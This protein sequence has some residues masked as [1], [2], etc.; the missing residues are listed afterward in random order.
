MLE[1]H[2]ASHLYPMNTFQALLNKRRNKFFP[3]ALVARRLKRA[4][5]IISKLKRFEQM[6]LSRMQDIGGLRFIAKS[7]T[8]VADM[9][10][11]YRAS[12]FLH[13]LSRSDDYINEPKDDGYRG[14]HLVYKYRKNSLDDWNGLSIELQ[15]RTFIQ[16]EWATALETVDTMLGTK[17]K[18]GKSARDWSRFF[19]VSSA[20]FSRILEGQGSH[21]PFSAMS[22]LAL[23]AELE[24]C[25][26][27]VGA[28]AKLELFSLS[29]NGFKGLPRSAYYLME[30]DSATSSMTVFG[31]RRDEILSAT[32]K[33]A[34]L[35]KQNSDS[36]AVDVV[37]VST[38]RLRDLK[39]AYPNYFADTA[40]FID[41][42]KQVRQRI[43]K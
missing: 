42:L 14:Y 31:F 28:M 7:C 29:V 9:V 40:N 21:G 43:G 5:S 38:T 22:D 34:E 15:F 3:D 18:A 26:A 23:V 20:C 35:E 8:D 17:M 13:E 33:Y 27:V 32:S 39:N 6:S 4:P 30:L 16:H 41:Q 10:E 2:R 25:E 1:N 24:K 19:R 37:L 11:E 12:R 36:S